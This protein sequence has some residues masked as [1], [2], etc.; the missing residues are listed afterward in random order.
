MKVNVVYM[1][2]TTSFITCNKCYIFNIDSLNAIVYFVFVIKALE[3][4]LKH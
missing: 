4:V 1:T 3:Q 2:I